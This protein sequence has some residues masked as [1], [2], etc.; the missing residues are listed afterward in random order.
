[1]G[2]GQRPNG[3][4]P[5]KVAEGKDIRRIVGVVVEK[6]ILTIVV[7]HY[8]KFAGEVHNQVSGLP[9]G[10]RLTGSITR[11]TKDRWSRGMDLLLEENL[12]T[13]QALVDMSNS[14]DPQI[15]FTGEGADDHVGGRVPMLDLH[16]W[17]SSENGAEVIK[18]CYYEKPITSP[19][20]RVIMEQS[21]LPARTKITV[22]TQE[23]VRRMR[24][25]SL[26]VQISERI[27]ILDKLMV[28]MRRS[29]YDQE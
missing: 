13:T 6:A 15:M 24:N 7:N 21:A 4:P 9:I 3:E 11:I 17:R 10:S 22:L 8:Y 1:M 29:G 12:V 2:Q 19:K 14:I 23:V 20:P 5:W 26:S 16:V 27:N 18:H 25:T 28:K